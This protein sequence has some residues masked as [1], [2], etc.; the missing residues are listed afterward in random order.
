AQSADRVAFEPDR[1]CSVSALVP[2]ILEHSSLNDTELRL[3]EVHDSNVGGCSG[4]EDLPEMRA[5]S[6]GPPDRAFHGLRGFIAR[7]GIRQALVEHHRNVGPEP[8][9]NIDRTLRR[10][11]V[12]GTIQM[13][14]KLGA[15]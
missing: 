7:R 14:A 8:C 15:L 9:L 5:A 3:T 11:P 4:V 2:K 10:Q 6:G 13:R 12:Q 1:D